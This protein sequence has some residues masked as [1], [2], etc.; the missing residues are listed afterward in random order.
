MIHRFSFAPRLFL[1]LRWHIGQRCKKMRRAFF[2]AT[3]RLSPDDA[4]WIILDC[5]TSADSYP[6]MVLT[7]D[8]VLD[9]AIALYGAPAR[10]LEPYLA[11]ACA[12]VARKWDSPGDE[13]YYARDWALSIARSAASEDGINLVEPDPDPDP[14][15]EKAAA[16]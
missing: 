1:L 16:A 3:D 13:Y 7:P 5:R 4:Q 6:L 2:Y 14:D 9:M 11:A 12:H 15:F 8:D 10:A